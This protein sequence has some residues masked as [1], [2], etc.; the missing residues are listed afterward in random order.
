MNWILLEWQ[1]GGKGRNLEVKE[2]RWGK[3]KKSFTY[4]LFC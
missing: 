3:D 2:G 1:G 4:Y